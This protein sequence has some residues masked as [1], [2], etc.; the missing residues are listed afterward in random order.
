MIVVKDSVRSFAMGDIGA[1]IHSK[2]H[3]HVAGSGNSLVRGIQ[4]HHDH[5]VAGSGKIKFR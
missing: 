2:V 3:A 1:F 4:P 5:S